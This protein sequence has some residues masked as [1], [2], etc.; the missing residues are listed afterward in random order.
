MSIPDKMLL[1]VSSLGGPIRNY[2]FYH[3]K[4]RRGATPMKALFRTT[5]TASCLV[6][7]IL[8]TEHGV[9]TQRVEHGS[10]VEHGEYLITASPSSRLPKEP[11]RMLVYESRS[12]NC[13]EIT[14]HG[15]RFLSWQ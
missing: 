5:F 3:V 15:P 9:E 10:D 13:S 6:N 11:I 7:S 14:S 2:T 4:T 12:K 1:I 8:L